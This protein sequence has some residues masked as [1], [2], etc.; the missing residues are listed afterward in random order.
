MVAT[1]DITGDSIISKPTSNLYRMNWDR[2][3]GWIP[4]TESL[5]PRGQEVEVRTTDNTVMAAFLC[6]CCGSDWRDTIAGECLII[7]V[8]HWR[9]V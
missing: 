1:N 4:I 9:V 8:S 3:F 7:D 5:P 6:Q 2:I